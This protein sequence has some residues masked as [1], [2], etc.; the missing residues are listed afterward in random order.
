MVGLVAR[1]YDPGCVHDWMPVLI[2]AQ[3]LGKSRFCQDLFPRAMQSRWHT[4]GVAVD[5]DTQ[6]L[7]EAAGPCWVAEFSEM[8]GIRSLRDVEHFKNIMSQRK[9]RYRRPYAVAPGDHLRGWAGIG[10][11]NGE[12]AIP[13]DPTGSRRYVAVQCGERADWD[14][15]PKNR[16]QLWAEALTIYKAQD[17]NK[18][19][20]NLIPLGWQSVQE[21]Q[22]DD[23]RVKVDS[24]SEDLAETL[25]QRRE[26]YEG[27]DKATKLVALW[28]AAH[29]PYT[30]GP[31]TPTDNIKPPSEKQLSVFGSQLGRLGWKSTRTTWPDGMRQVR[32][33]FS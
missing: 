20:R 3:G 16:E 22:N 17:E 1:A 11:A 7:S 24:V 2:G 29:S 25:H 14:Y 27:V 30:A 23:F 8:R 12:E 21:V 13:D 15:V 33:W 9:D 4:D 18:H 5:Q 31:L 19:P 10:T 26:K 32:W 28:T 6:R